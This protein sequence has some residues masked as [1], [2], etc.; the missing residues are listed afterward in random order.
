MQ[1]KVGLKFTGGENAALS[2]V[3]EYFWKKVRYNLDY[4]VGLT[5]LDSE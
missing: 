5:F 3:H 2:R 4:F 1:V